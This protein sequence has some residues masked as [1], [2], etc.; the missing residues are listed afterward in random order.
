MKV[1]LYVLPYSHPAMAA[2]AMLVHKG[3]DH[4]VTELPAGAHPP[5][6]RALGFPGGTVPA[7]KVDGR[8]VQ[9][10]RAIARLLEELRAEPPLFPTDASR[11]APVEEAERWGEE[12]LQPLPRRFFRWGL[13]RDRAL[14][15]WFERACGTPA[16]GLVA[17]VEGPVTRVFAR[18]SRADDETVKENLRDLPGMLDRVDALMAGGTLGGEPPNAADFQIA[19][20]IRVFMEQ[21]SI[22]PLVAGRPATELAARLFPDLDGPIPLRLPPEWLPDAG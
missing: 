4:K 8:R 18:K 9:G 19:S 22:R 10:S 21:E 20:S 3:I 16:P 11:R 1:R 12:E 5:I 13:V 6:L 2:R 7:V 17:A 15:A 14:R